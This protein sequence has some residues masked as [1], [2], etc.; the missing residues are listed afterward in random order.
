M[1]CTIGVDVAYDENKTRPDIL[2]DV[3]LR[4]LSAGLRTYADKFADQGVRVGF[5]ADGGVGPSDFGDVRPV[6]DRELLAVAVYEAVFHATESFEE[7]AVG[8]DLAYL[9]GG[10]VK[11][12]PRSYWAEKGNVLLRILRAEFPDAAH[13]VWPYVEI[14]EGA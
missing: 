6:G 13:P 11:G 14:E 3:L 7:D 5:V 10:I 1:K 12:T 2:A 8:S 9:L 4:A